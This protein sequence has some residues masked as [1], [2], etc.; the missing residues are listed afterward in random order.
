MSLN[1]ACTSGAQSGSVHL[2]L[3]VEFRSEM[4]AA[5]SEA[6][7]EQCPE[8]A[9]LFGL[10]ALVV[11]PLQHAQGVADRLLRGYGAIDDGLAMVAQ[12]LGGDRP[13]H[14]V[15]DERSWVAKSSLDEL[16]GG[17]S[18][19]LSTDRLVPTLWIARQCR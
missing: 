17:I 14:P 1:H 2:V 13:E 18:G 6:G 5:V 19:D 12:L 9:F 8:I 3:E 15:P 7:L 11:L 10:E 4:F 16:V